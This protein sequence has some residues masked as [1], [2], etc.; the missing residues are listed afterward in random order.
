M[1]GPHP[2]SEGAARSRSTNAD[3]FSAF[4]F[5]KSEL[6]A[7]GPAVDNGL[8][9]PRVDVFKLVRIV[10]VSGTGLCDN[11]ATVPRTGQLNL[12]E[13]CLGAG[14]PVKSCHLQHVVT[15]IAHH[16]HQSSP[17]GRFHMQ[18]RQQIHLEKSRRGCW[19]CSP[20]ED[21]GNLGIGNWA[22][23][24]APR[25]CFQRPPELGVVKTHSA[26]AAL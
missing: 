18:H 10:P 17:Q 21:P 19:L 7:A 20:P 4:L 2:P 23:P 14:P 16:R 5:T 9:I 3:I 25:D 8:L 15:G 13:D 26:V 6:E 1:P 12:I 24:A 22:L 11:C